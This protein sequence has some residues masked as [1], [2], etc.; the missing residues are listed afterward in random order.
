M[1]YASHVTVCYLGSRLNSVFNAA[2][3]M[4]RDLMLKNP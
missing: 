4:T 2:L 3:N 1:V